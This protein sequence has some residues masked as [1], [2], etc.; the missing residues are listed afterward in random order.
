MKTS[1]RK[2]PPKIISYRN[3]NNFTHHSFRNEVIEKLRHYDLN[4]ISYENFERIII[5]CINIH[6]PKKKK[7]IRANES[8]FMT[9]ELRKAIMVRSKLKN[10]FN[11]MKTD[12]NKLMYN[13]QRNKCTSLLR[14]TKKNYFNR[15]NPSLITDNKFFWRVIKPLFSEKCFTNENI[16]LIEKNEIIEDDNKISEIFND[17]FTNAVKNLNIEIDQNILNNVDDIE[18]PILKAIKK[19]QKHPSIL[20]INEN[21]LQN[22]ENFEFKTITQESL[23]SEINI[24]NAK[25]A[26]QIDNI[27]IK[28][29]K[30][31]ADIFSLVLHNIINKSLDFS[32]FPDKLKLAD[33]TPVHK[34]EDRND[35]N[36][37]RPVSILPSISKIFE[38]I[39][40]TQ[41]YQHVEKKLSK[42]QC[43]FR[44]NFSAQ[45]CIIFM[46][47]KWKHSLDKR[48][49]CG[50]LLTDLSKAFDCLLHELLIAKLHAYG[51]NYSSLKLIYSYLN[52]RFQRVKINSMYSSWSQILTGVP[53][54]SILGPLL[55][56]IYLIDL[57]FFTKGSDIV[58]YADDNTP[59]T[60]K[61]DI[62]SVIEQ[63]EKDSK[64]LLNWFSNNALKANPDKFHLLLSDTN[65]DI[66][67]IVDNYEIRNNKHKKLLG[68]IIDNKMKFEEHISKLCSKASQKLHALARVS[69]FMKTEQN[70]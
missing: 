58:N 42:Y 39:L 60:C 50:T 14:K 16:T 19:Y 45:Q 66:N 25:K 2:L 69:N 12:E 28:I 8:P 23:L 5:T 38:K 11:T 40:Y 55:F 34:K 49:S 31:N 7:C 59:F 37:Y 54:G 46:L 32:I 24:L 41:I 6:A 51:F 47:E 57:F 13:K 1:F 17:F 22:K 35:K 67:I 43:G 64:T 48:L 53:Q 4:E 10:K 65:E 52:N 61:D 63:L 56:N 29:I 20:K 15:L 33:V 68:I 62:N 30:H 9:K 27:P 26:T 21:Q 44:K 18:D 3:Y 36:N 70:K